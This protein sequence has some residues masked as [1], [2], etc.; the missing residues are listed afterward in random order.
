[1]GRTTRICQGMYLK[2][3]HRLE[4]SLTNINRQTTELTM[5]SDYI[6]PIEQCLMMRPFTICDVRF[7]QVPVMSLRR[8]TVTS[9][10]LLY[11]CSFGC[12][13]TEIR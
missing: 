13:K 4:K 5:H 2:S 12:A 6:D 1:M 7:G 11:K 3:G 9:L 10:G 8:Q